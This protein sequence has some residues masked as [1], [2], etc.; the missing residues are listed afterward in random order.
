MRMSR[1]AA[2]FAVLGWAV[3][4]LWPYPAGANVI[5]N[6][7][8]ESGPILSP[9]GETP[10]KS[11]WSSTADQLGSWYAY[12]SQYSIVQEGGNKYAQS[13]VPYV[14][15]PGAPKNDSYR[16]LMQ[17][18]AAPALGDYL[19]SVDYRLAGGSAAQIA[20]IRIMG[21]IEREN[22]AFSIDLAGGYNANPIYGAA[23]EDIGNISLSGVGTPGQ[24]NTQSQR[25][26]INN[27]NFDYVVVWA[28]VSQPAGSSG[29]Y[30]D[31]DN[32]SLSLVP[33]PSTYALFGLMLLGLVG[34]TY[35]SRAS[36]P[37]VVVVARRQS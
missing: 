32:L 30:A 27:D 8:F 34:W 15:K 36:S 12:Q 26:S 7:D 31:L 16:K 6:G 25:I 11:V 1:Y 18:I 20:D 2:V 3:V 9:A 19:F 29:Q 28:W 21:I 24:W 37:A 5:A 13:D 14:G 10:K 23:K 35:W 4:G 33:E 17:V 22:R